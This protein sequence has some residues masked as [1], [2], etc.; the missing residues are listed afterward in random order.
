M[1]S[2]AEFIFLQGGFE[3]KGNKKRIGP[4]KGGYWEILYG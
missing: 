3:R 4:D 1:G 2:L